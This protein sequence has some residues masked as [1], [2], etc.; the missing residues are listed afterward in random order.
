MNEW[1][2]QGEERELWE[3][4]SECGGREVSGLDSEWERGGKQAGVAEVWAGPGHGPG[5]P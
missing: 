2:G 4:N 3:E 5:N 1:N